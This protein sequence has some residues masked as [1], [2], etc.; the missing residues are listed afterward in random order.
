MLSLV[1]LLT[2]VSHATS[3]GMVTS[4]RSRNWVAYQ[5]GGSSGIGVPPNEWCAQCL[6]RNTG[7]C[8][9][10]TTYD[11][12]N[13]LD[14]QGTPMAWNAQATYVQGSIVTIEFRITAYHMGHVEIKACPD[15][16]ASTQA[17]FDEHPLVLVQDRLH[18][19]APDPSYPERAYLGGSADMYIM[20]F[21]LPVD[22]SGPQVLLQVRKW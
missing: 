22:V 11:Y 8:G 15:G 17:C 5:D 20:D 2:L 9:K 10:A 12:D 3:H 13:W 18:G 6:N 14:V 4:P 19:M 21:Q 7:V 16:R 1:L